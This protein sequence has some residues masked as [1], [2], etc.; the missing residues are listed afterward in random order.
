MTGIS[1]FG[2]RDGVIL[3][4]SG[5][6]TRLTFDLS[7]VEVTAL[8]ASLIAA[9]RASQTDRPT[10]EA[11]KASLPPPGRVRAAVYLADA[12]CRPSL[13]LASSSTWST[14]PWYLP[15]CSLIASR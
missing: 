10:V 6:D 15:A 14:V 11:I 4:V 13:M 3:R 8:I 12:C 1:A 2:M 7:P 9:Q 5:H